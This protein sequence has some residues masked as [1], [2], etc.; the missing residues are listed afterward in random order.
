MGEGSH[1]KSDKGKV[2]NDVGIADTYI[3]G[4][5]DCENEFAEPDDCE[6]E[7]GEL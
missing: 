7:G 5:V 6:Y 1:L 2:R 4:E 3:C